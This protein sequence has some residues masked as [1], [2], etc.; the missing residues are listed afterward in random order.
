MGTILLITKGGS[1]PLA[2]ATSSWWAAPR[3][4]AVSSATPTPSGSAPKTPMFAKIFLLYLKY[5]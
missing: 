5:G 1:V 2:S 4:L 3:H